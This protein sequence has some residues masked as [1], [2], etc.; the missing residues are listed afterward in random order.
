MSKNRMFR[1]VCFII[2]MLAA[3]L[4]ISLERADDAAYD[5]DAVAIKALESSK[6]VTVDETADYIVFE[7]AGEFYNKGIIFYPGGSVEPEAYAPLMH[8][9]AEEGYLCVIVKMPLKLAVLDVYKADKV[10]KDF[11]NIA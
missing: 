3:V 8:A 2:F 9:V 11:S 4:V 6:Y 5:A 10:R 1:M 7:P